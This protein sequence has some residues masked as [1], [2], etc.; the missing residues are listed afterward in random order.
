MT[1]SKLLILAFAVALSG[2]TPAQPKLS[3]D[4]AEECRRELPKEAAGTA[5]AKDKAHLAMCRE[6]DPKQFP[7]VGGTR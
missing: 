5:G 3:D 4:D 7:T 6:N 2:C 1:K